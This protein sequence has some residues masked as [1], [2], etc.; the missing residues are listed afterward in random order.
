MHVGT[1][2]VADVLGDA[3]CYPHTHGYELR[4]YKVSHPFLR[5]LFSTRPQP[6]SCDS[7]AM[8][9]SGIGLTRM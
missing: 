6:E 8:S 1:G 4:R 9:N 3:L 5:A 7:S 2:T